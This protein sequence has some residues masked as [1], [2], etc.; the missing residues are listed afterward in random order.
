MTRTPTK[1]FRR[2]ARVASLAVILAVV[3]APGTAWAD[4]IETS[5]LVLS[6]TAAGATATYTLTYQIG[7]DNGHLAQADGPTL[8]VIFPAD[9]DIRGVALVASSSGICDCDTR[10]LNGTF[11]AFPSFATGGGVTVDNS[12]RSVTIGPL[13]VATTDGRTAFRVVLSGVVNRTTMGSMALTAQVTDGNGVGSKFGSFPNTNGPVLYT[14]SEAS[15]PPSAPPVVS[16]TT[17]PRAHP[18]AVAV[19]QAA[20]LEGIRSVLVRSAAPVPVTT[21]ISP[22]T[23]PRGGL[24]IEDEDRS[25]RVS[26]A[27]SAGVSPTAGVVVPV[28]GEVVCE[29]CAQLVAGSVVEAWIYSAPRLS[30]AVQVEIDAAE[31]TCP[32]LRIPTGAPLDGGGA[33]EPGVHTLQLRM[34]TENGF[35]ILS[36]PIRVGGPVPS[37]VPSGEGTGLPLGLLGAV[38]G[39]AALG[40]AIGLRR[41]VPTSVSTP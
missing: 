22:S 7:F 5:T 21:A 27:T 33:I 41:R 31:G 4:H 6:D 40:A 32:L 8:K 1:S 26:V 13:A 38:A 29:I 18:V 34:E 2:A 36:L 14:L 35:E 37:G 28:G 24:V 39:F 30:A 20:G 10:S 25:L 19:E 17:D 12:A 16:R 23:G 3:A 11:S 9:T 15:A